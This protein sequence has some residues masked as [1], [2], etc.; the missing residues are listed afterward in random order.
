[1]HVCVG[2]VCLCVFMVGGVF[3]GKLIGL[4]KLGVDEEL[5]EF[6]FGCSSA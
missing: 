6:V 3:S 5:W 2:L 4:D 1:M